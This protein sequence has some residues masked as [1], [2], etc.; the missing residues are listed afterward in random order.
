M[1]ISIYF[2]TC[3]M[4]IGGHGGGGGGRG[5]GGLKYILKIINKLFRYV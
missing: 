5:G 2:I 4:H 1:G 3:G